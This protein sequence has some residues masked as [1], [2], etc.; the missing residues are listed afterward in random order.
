M[1]EEQTPEVSAEE[2]VPVE[3]EE[4]KLDK[5]E[6][7]PAPKQTYKVKVDGKEIEATDDD[8]PEEDRALPAK[9]MAIAAQKRMAAAAE[10]EKAFSGFVEAFKKDPKEAL[11]KHAGFTKEDLLQ[12]AAAVAEEHLAEEELSPEQKELRQLKAEKAEYEK[13]LTEQHTQH[14]STLYDTTIPKALAE[15]DLPDSGFARAVISQFLV[16]KIDSEYKDDR[17]GRFDKDYPDLLREAVKIV[18]GLLDGHGNYYEA[19]KK[20][21]KP[22]V[23]VTPVEDSPDAEVTRLADMI[24]KGLLKK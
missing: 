12:F 19:R 20:R 21:A 23:P 16:N 15:V 18:E 5:V 9:Q 10:K 11:T 13:M 7:A 8:I 3:A 24:R 4:P 14:Y 22:A 2:V 1:S 17:S 6:E